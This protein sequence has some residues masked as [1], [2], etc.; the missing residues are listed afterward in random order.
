VLVGRETDVVRRNGHLGLKTFGV[1]RDKSQRAWRSVLRQLFAAGAVEETGGEYPGLRLT[2]KGEAIL[3]GRERIALRAEVERRA[4]RE[5]G[6]LV[7]GAAVG[8]APGDEPLLQH[9]RA[10]RGAIARGEGV[11]AFMVFPDRTLIEMAK[12][13]PLDLAAL[14]LVHG[15]GERKIAAYGPAFVNAVRGFLGQ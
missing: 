14:R 8:L 3:F 2:E 4:R 15:V 1:G 7:D 5:R 13:R 9:L 6:I 11:A 10:V 12:L